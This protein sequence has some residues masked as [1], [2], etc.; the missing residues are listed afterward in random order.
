MST[1]FPRNMQLIKKS[2]R[3]LS[4][5]FH[6]RPDSSDRT[7]PKKSRSSKTPL[8][9][10]RS[11]RRR[12]FKRRTSSSSSSSPS[13]AARRRTMDMLICRGEMEKKKMKRK[14]EDRDDDDD[15]DWEFVQCKKRLV[16]KS[17][18]R[19][20]AKE[21]IEREQVPCDGMPHPL[22]F[23]SEA[24]DVEL[25]E[26]PDDYEELLE[27]VHSNLENLAITDTD[28][29][30]PTSITSTHQTSPEPRTAV[31][32]WAWLEGVHDWENRYRARRCHSESSTRILSYANAVTGELPD[33][34]GRRPGVMGSWEERRTWVYMWWEK[35]KKKRKHKWE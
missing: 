12:K 6:A 14:R 32:D 21:G 2:R 23:H 10:S 24:S 28:D 18:A 27:K 20:F 7:A 25:G 35:T 1:L 26:L 5:I 9:S 11:S 4:G 16:V 22:P 30:F 19:V 17:V 34:S 31:L 29:S 33:G 13:V 8:S 3:M 15:D